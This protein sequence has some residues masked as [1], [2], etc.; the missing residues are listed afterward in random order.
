MHFAK[1]IRFTQR[2][3]S[4][5]SKKPTKKKY[6]HLKLIFSKNGSHIK[7][8]IFHAKLVWKLDFALSIERFLAGFFSMELII[9]V[10]IALLVFKHCEI[11]S[12]FSIE[13]FFFFFYRSLHRVTVLDRQF[14]N[15]LCS[16]ATNHF[17]LL[18]PHFGE[19]P[20]NCYANNDSIDAIF[21]EKKKPYH[22][23]D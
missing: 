2:F 18:I 3:S 12:Q 1:D 22:L 21:G 7:R 4:F 16:N 19:L 20:E 23:H 17:Q 5:F 10:N 14:V 11:E 13:P 15:F 8:P 9:I 6:F